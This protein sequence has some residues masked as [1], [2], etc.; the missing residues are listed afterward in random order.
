MRKM[1]LEQLVYWD[2][3]AL[4]AGEDMDNFG[5]ALANGEAIANA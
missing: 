1:T 2:E 3:W 4:A 5:E